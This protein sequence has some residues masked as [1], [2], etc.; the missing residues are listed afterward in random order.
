M[1]TEIQD[2]YIFVC[3]A[4]TDTR[5]RVV[6]SLNIHLRGLELLGTLHYQGEH[7][8]AVLVE[9]LDRNLKSV[10]QLLYKDLYLSRHPSTYILWWINDLDDRRVL[11]NR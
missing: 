7:I 8:G 2:Y 3:Q 9:P 10:I 1:V 6:G 4:I 5:H 11:L